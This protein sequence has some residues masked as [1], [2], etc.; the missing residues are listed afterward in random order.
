MKKIIFIWLL[1]FFSTTCFARELNGFL[2]MPFG[3][4]EKTVQSVMEKK[5]STL[6]FKHIKVDSFIMDGGMF[7]GRQI[8]FILFGFIDKKLYTANA[9]LKTN[10]KVNIQDFFDSLRKEL[11]EKYGESDYYRVFT[12]P[13]NDG[14]GDELQAIEGGFAEI[15]SYWIFDNGNAI[16]I[17]ITKDLDIKLV[18]QDGKLIDQVIEK[19]KKK[20]KNDL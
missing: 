11:D 17:K 8:D 9:Y 13:Y 18:Y 16:T 1:L 2:G 4:D 6:D 12:R 15:K 20:N 7:A 5:G 19:Q 10:D 14:E 3:S